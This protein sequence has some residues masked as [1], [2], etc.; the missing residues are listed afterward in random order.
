[1]ELLPLCS[2]SFCL[3]EG[4]SGESVFS[5]NELKPLGWELRRW[6]GRMRRGG[7]DALELSAPVLELEQSVITL[8]PNNAYIAGEIPEGFGF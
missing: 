8:V 3:L 2:G 6:C 7:V 4:L 1:M 5:V